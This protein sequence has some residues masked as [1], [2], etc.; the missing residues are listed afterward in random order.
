MPTEQQ[1]YH[2]AKRN[3]QFLESF[4]KTYN[5]NDWS[6]TVAFYAALHVIEYASNFIKHI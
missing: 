1:H 4:Y 6:V 5:Y 2:Q 3:I